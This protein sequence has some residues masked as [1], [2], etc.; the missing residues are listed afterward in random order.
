MW[1]SFQIADG[2]LFSL[3]AGQQGKREVNIVHVIA[4]LHGQHASIC[5]WG[6]RE[7][8]GKAQLISVLIFCCSSWACEPVYKAHQGKLGFP[9]LLC[10]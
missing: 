10:L 2:H 9:S 6:G 1:P 4:K 3:L 7:G 5:L 8:G